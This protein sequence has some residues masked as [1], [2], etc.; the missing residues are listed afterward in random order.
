MKQ[1]TDYSNSAV[2][3]VN[4]REV[5]NL[6]NIR[7]NLVKI[8]YEAESN[9]ENTP[10]YRSVNEANKKIVEL[11]KKLRDAMDEYGSYQDL[12][13]GDYAIKQ[14]RQTVNYTPELVRQNAP[15]KI[16]KYVIVEAVDSNALN[17]LAKAHEI[18]AEDLLKCGEVRETFAY[19]I[20]QEPPES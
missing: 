17:A 14:R 13:H 12:E 15:E 18:T 1:P 5:E 10:E 16:A 8:Q 19:I 2:N 4:P 7:T 11:D 6:L 20:K 9:L 3:L